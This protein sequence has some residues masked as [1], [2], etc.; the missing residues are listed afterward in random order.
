GILAPRRLAAKVR[1]ALDTALARV[2]RLR[3]VRAE[4]T[5]APWP[6]GAGWSRRQQ[7]L[8]RLALLHPTH[9]GAERVE[10]RRRRSA[11]VIHAGHEEDTRE[12]LRVAQ[13]TVVR[14]QP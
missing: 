11:A 4:R 8:R 2:T 9:H 7:A 10:L 12:F 14:D 3:R 5:R 6:G 13:P 1:R